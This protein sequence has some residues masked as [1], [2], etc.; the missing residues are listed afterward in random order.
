MNSFRP[1]VYKGS[2]AVERRHNLLAL[3]LFAC[4]F[5]AV[6]RFTLNPVNAAICA[7]PYMLFLVNMLR[8][9]QRTALACL[10]LALCLSVDNGAGIHAETVSPLRYLIYTSAIVMLFYLSL[11]R[12]RKKSLI[13][14]TLLCCYILIGSM[15]S[16]LLGGAPLD[17]AT[18]RRD[19]MVLFI[20]SVFLLARSPVRLDLHLL[21][22]GSLGYLAGEVLNTLISYRE[23]T[24]YLSYNSLKIFI[25]FPLIH[26]IITRKNIVI[27]TVFAALTVYVISLYG[28]RMITLSVILLFLTASIVYMIRN[29]YGKSL[30][31]FLI[32]WILL[33]NFNLVEILRDGGFLKFKA[34][35]FLFQAIDILKE[36]EI[37]QVLAV[38]DPIRFAEHQL[39]FDRPMSLIFFGSGLGSGIFDSNGALGFVTLDHT[40]FSE[41]EINS[42]SYFGFHDFWIDFGLRFGILPVV[43]FVFCLTLIPMW[44]RFYVKGVLF[45]LV[46][47]NATFAT[48]GILLMALLVRFWPEEH[49]L[50][51]SNV[52]TAEESK[53]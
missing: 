33:T 49:P 12:V 45:G 43:Y 28:T 3:M 24:D 31:G 42:S 38:L 47:I 4:G 48:S 20:L 22:S 25:V 15:A 23:F 44:R 9:H 7:V 5:L 46:L 17:T 19:L 1:G 34:I 41:E 26:S 32:T 36:S 14:A 8:G 50:S 2:T 51:E 21:Y 52:L 16:L 30:L 6:Q 18:L 40:A 29:G 11:W 27:Q 13:L 39:F 10:V 53:R 37:T 35:A